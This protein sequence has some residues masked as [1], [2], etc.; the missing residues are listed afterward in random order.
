M[1]SYKSSSF[2]LRRLRPF[3]TLSRTCV[4]LHATGKTKFYAVAKGREP[5]IYETWHDCQLQVDGFSGALYKSFT[6]RE[7]SEAYLR[8]AMKG[9]ASKDAMKSNTLSKSSNPIP[10]ENKLDEYYHINLNFDGG[11]RGNG[12][13]V[14]PIAGSGAVL[15]VFHKNQEEKIYIRKFIKENNLVST[16]NYAEYTGLLEGLKEIFK[17][18]EHILR[19]PTKLEIFGDSLLVIK[20]VTGEYVCRS[21]NLK[22]LY[23]EVVGMIRKM[24]E[25]GVT[26]E[27]TH[28]YRSENSEADV[29]ANEAMD[30]QKSWKTSPVTHQNE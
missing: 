12:K 22:G 19:E 30:Q 26:V 1:A 7:K 29:L 3:I 28:I 15:K 21:C 9:D 11:S 25:K 2:S 20:Q 16:N 13:T 24:K 6:N 27:V 23:Q 17:N 10:K 8:D 14:S 4:V 5:G 18:H